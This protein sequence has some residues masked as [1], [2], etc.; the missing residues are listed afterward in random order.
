VVFSFLLLRRTARLARWHRE[1]EARP[2]IPEWFY[3]LLVRCSRR[4]DLDRVP[5]IVFSKEAVT[6]AVY[7]VFRPVLLLPAHYTESLASE[8][9]EHVLLHELAHL[10]RGDLLV[11]GGILA[12]QII[13]WFNPFVA[14]ARRQV[15]HLREICCDLTVANLLE[16]ETMSYR[17]TLLSTARTLLTE[18]VQPSLGLLG[19]FEEPHKLVTR[20]RWL[21]RDT[22][23][24]HRLM[25]STALLVVLL[26][27]PFVLPMAAT[28]PTLDEVAETIG[29]PPPAAPAPIGEVRRIG[30]CVHVRNVFRVDKVFLGFVVESQKRE[31]S[32]MW[33]GEDIIL[34]TERN[35][36]TI[37]EPTR[38]KLT[39]ID[40]DT[41]VWIEVPLPLDVTAH[42]TEK[43]Q[44]EWRGIRSTGKVEDTGKREKIL[45]R[46]CQVF[47][48][49]SWRVSG[50]G[51]LS[52]ETS[53]KVW[54]TT[55]VPFDIGLLDQLLFNLRLIYNRDAA[56]R[57]ELV[58]VEG[59]QMR[60]EMRQGSFVAGQRYVDEVMEI[61]TATPPPGTFDPPA[62]YRQVDMIHELRL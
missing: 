18:S 20:V 33:I 17:K 45:D 21:E 25:L 35:R 19:V 10:K 22:W 29:T 31:V 54:S 42:L 39:F 52:A 53:Y 55:D 36:T 59:L 44:R 34:A 12:L 27:A 47:E 46:K 43:M 30:E 61:T 62:G 57:E 41:E 51:V 60:L 56:F 50:G 15:K 3:D 9:A 23:R 38:A 32:E 48:V 13:Y 6:P 7:G 58:K 1:Q 4:L 11:H 28:T 49:T 24:R 37:L 40:H 5:A 2:T 14:M 16:E 8:E 26:A